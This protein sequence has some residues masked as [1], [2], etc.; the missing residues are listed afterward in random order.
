MAYQG[1]ASLK[2]NLNLK[3]V[4]KSS[5]N[6]G[7]LNII[8]SGNEIKKRITLNGKAVR[9]PSIINLLNQSLPHS[10]EKAE[11]RCWKAINFL[12]MIRRQSFRPIIYAKLLKIPN[13]YGS[14][15]LRKHTLNGEI[16]DYGLV[17]LKLV[18]DTGVDFIIDAFQNI[19]EIEILKFH[20]IGTGSTAEAQT[21]TA[22]V[23]EL[24]TQYNPDNIRATGTTIEGGSTNIYRTVGTNLLDASVAL[25]EHGIFSQAAT[26]GGTML[27]RSLYALINLVS[28]E[29]LQSTYDLT[30]NAGG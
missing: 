14:L 27:D 22:L 13:F 10:W 23:T 12:G 7:S 2:G 1:I 20:G 18:T 11:I 9:G 15:R 19:T 24:T 17:C 26:G 30:V 6:V 4:P 16:L 25:R 21:E 5:K 3:I 29:S 8:V 28:G